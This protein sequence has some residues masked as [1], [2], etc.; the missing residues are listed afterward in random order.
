MTKHILMCI[1]LIIGFFTNIFSE[2]SRPTLLRSASEYDYPPF[3]IVNPDSS[4][5]GFSVEL[6]QAACDAMNLKIEFKVDEWSVIKRELADGKLDV[7]PLV[8]RTPEREELYDF[9]FPYMT[10]HGAVFAKKGEN[11]FKTR[12]DLKNAKLMVMKGDNAEEYARRVKLTS[13]IETV[14]SFEQAFRNLSEGKC[15]IVVTQK[16]MGLN[17]IN[18]AGISNVEPL[19]IEIN[20]FQ[21]NFC[22]AV[23]NDNDSLLSILNEGLSIIIANGTFDRLHQKWFTPKTE[24]GK[25]TLVVAGDANYP[26]FSF[27][28]ENGKYTGPDVEV[29]HA[30]AKDLG[31]L[32][33][34]KPEKWSELMENFKNGEYDAIQAILFSEEREKYMDFSIP[35]LV[36]TYRIFAN[37]KTTIPENLSDLKNYKVAVEKDNIIHEIA[38]QAGLKDDLIVTGSHEEALLKLAAGEADYALLSYLTAIH[39]IKKHEIKNIHYCDNDHYTA[40][41]CYAVRKGDIVLLRNINNAIAGLKASGRLREINAKWFGA[42][43][44]ESFNY[45]RVLK[46]LAVFFAFLL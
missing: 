9:T 11:R 27:I 7:L 44:E 43:H 12:D 34:L 35:Y 13:D 4:A 45:S 10:Y 2:Q 5:G 30:I 28:D 3:C 23:I 20:D 25:T 26:P 29:S 33:D 24:I 1:L 8:G 22:F 36:S 15:D 32:I 18:L 14:E 38:L 37:K 46:Y 17:L 31:V 40:E 41:F 39:Y 19:D 16:V 42:Y 21:Q 6:L